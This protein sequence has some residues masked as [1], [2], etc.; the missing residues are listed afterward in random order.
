MK[1]SIALLKKEFTELF[2][3]L[4]KQIDSNTLVETGDGFVQGIDVT[5]GFYY[6]RETDE[7]DWNFQ[8]GDNSFTGP[9]YSFS[10]WVTTTLFRKSN[11]AAI[12]QEV[13]DEISNTV[14]E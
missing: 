3:Q 5:I 11:S 2:K 10:D 12:A 9:C 7:V 6:D 1:K 13:V 14:G 8:T 4:K